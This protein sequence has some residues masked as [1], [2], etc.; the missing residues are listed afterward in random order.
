MAAHFKVG[1]SV[2]VTSA[3]LTGCQPGGTGTVE[4]VIS[5]GSRGA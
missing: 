4:A 1:A 2:R 3:W 5:L